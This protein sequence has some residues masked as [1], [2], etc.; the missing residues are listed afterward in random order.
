MKK[1]FLV[2]AAALLLPSL[3]SARETKTSFIELQGAYANALNMNINAIAAQTEG[4]ISG[5][6][7]NIEEEF[8]K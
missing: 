7:F 5:M 8:V 1:I 4:F 2:L 3:I 6:P